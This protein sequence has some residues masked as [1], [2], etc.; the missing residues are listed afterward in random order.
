MKTATMRKKCSR[1]VE[2]QDSEVGPVFEDAGEGAGCGGGGVE[3]GGRAAAI[4]AT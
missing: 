2:R 1:V 3:G 4:E